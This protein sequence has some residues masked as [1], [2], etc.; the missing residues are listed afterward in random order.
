[1]ICSTSRCLGLLACIALALSACDDGGG[2]NAGTDAG[3]DASEEE[4]NDASRAEDAGPLRDSARD[5]SNSANDAAEDPYQCEPPPE[6]EGTIAAGQPCCD[7]LGT[8]LALG[9][10]AGSSLGI[11][12]CNATQGLRCT[13]ASA[14]GDAGAGNDAGTSALSTCRYR[15]GTQDGGADYEGRCV[16]ACLTRGTSTLPQGECQDDFVCV[17]CYNLITGASTGACDNNGDRPVDPAPPGFE[18]CGDALGYCIPAS[19]V[20][21][22]GANLQQLTCEADERCAPKQRVEDADGCWAR[23]DS[24]FGAG[25]C[26]PA[27]LIPVESRGTLQPASCATGELCS[28]CI[29]PTNMMRTGACN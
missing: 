26:L 16:P 28:P 18:E 25:A 17:P 5:T 21:P 14:P 10:D 6:P 23:C 8:C 1:M 22:T 19:S 24:V 11:G 29:N 2:S 9:D 20:G 13:P 4:T 12:D 27:F 7:G 3:M 15:T